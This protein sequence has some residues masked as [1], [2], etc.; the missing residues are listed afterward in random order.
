MKLRH[1]MQPL[2]V[3]CLALPLAAWAQPAEE[4]PG[5]DYDGLLVR[6]DINATM[7]GGDLEVTVTILDDRILQYATRELKDYLLPL[8]E[9]AL[10]QSTVYR[11]GDPKPPVPFLI[12]FRALGQEVRYEPHELVVYNVGTEF[13]PLEV[14][15]IDPGFN[16]RVA[17]IRRPPVAAVYLFDG[18]IDLNSRD[19]VVTYYNTLNWGDWMRVIEKVNEA[20]AHYQ[21]QQ[22]RGG[23]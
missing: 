22:A 11:P 9:Q 1:L 23:K 4:L 2:M 8:R 16:N 14:I 21:V 3:L 7:R 18:A 5:A 10:A 17:Y 12:T 20:K 19:L 6:N 15:P 13:K